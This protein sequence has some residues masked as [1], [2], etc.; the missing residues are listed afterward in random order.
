MVKRKEGTSLCCYRDNVSEK[1][2]KGHIILPFSQ[3][4]GLFGKEGARPTYKVP[5]IYL[6]DGQ[7]P[8]ILYEGVDN[9]HR[10]RDCMTTVPGAAIYITVTWDG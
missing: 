7:H 4:T 10:E 2:S 8:C 3:W 1:S 6:P 9:L 5:T